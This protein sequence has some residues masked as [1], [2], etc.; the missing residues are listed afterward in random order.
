MEKMFSK[1]LTKKI[2]EGKKLL[3]S[4]TDPNILQCS[5]IGTQ[6]LNS[7][8]LN[9]TRNKLNQ[10]ILRTLLKMNDEN[11]RPLHVQYVGHRPG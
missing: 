2:H 3:I 11:S 4:K 7:K 8:L 1:R 9:E 5:Y 10:K 6:F